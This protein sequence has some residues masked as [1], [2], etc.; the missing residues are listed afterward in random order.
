LQSDRRITLDELNA[1]AC[2]EPRLLIDTRCVAEFNGDCYDY[3]PRKGNLPNSVLFPFQ[4]YY[5]SN[6]NFAQ[7]EVYLATKPVVLHT[8]NI[9]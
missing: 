1:P 8:A 7:R 5:L 9:I 3:Q 4:D 6:G 2:Q